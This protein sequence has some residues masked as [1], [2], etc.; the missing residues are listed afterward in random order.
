MSGDP[1]AL[2]AFI[3]RHREKIPPLQA[4]LSA[5]GR[6]RTS[7]LRRE[8]LAML[9]GVSA[10]WITWIEQGRPVRPSLP[11]LDRL[12]KVLQLSHA[13]R[14]HLFHLAGKSDPQTEPRPSAVA[15]SLLHILHTLQYPAYIL[16]R[17]WNASA[18]NAAAATH[19]ID[20][21]PA[22]PV[23]GEKLP[24][25]LEFLLLHPHARQF[26]DDWESRC[27][28]LVAEF[29]ADVGKHLDDPEMMRRIAHLQSQSSTFADLWSAQDVVEREGGLRVFQHPIQGRVTYEQNTLLPAA[30]TD[31]KLVILLPYPHEDTRPD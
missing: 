17:Y 27:R 18:W 4:G 20:W 19:F 21:L 9:S 1:L 7:G 15:P 5:S 25:L 2:G 31:M 3:R 6:R 16:D 28:R 23:F 8:E 22:S 12:G 26:V 30:H 11:T 29:R 24:N 13:E 10:T 14:Q